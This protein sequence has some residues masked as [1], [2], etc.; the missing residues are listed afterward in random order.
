MLVRMQ[1]KGT[2]IHWR[3]ECKLAQP[4]WKTIWRLHKNLKIEGG[5]KWR[6]V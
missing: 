6:D 3:W 1:G 4:L 2:L 5:G